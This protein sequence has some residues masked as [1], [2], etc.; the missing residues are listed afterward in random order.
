M[1]CLYD[2][3]DVLIQIRSSSHNNIV[4]I[5][6]SS[7]LVL[8]PHKSPPSHGRELPYESIAYISHGS[9]HGGP[10]SY[11]AIIARFKL[12]YS[13]LIR[14]HISTSVQE[15]QVLGF[16]DG[17]ALIWGGVLLSLHARPLLDLE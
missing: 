17:A 1:V 10:L 9:F 5:N 2:R 16:L 3:C 15:H 6:L 11:L 7:H 13:Y 12:M 4:E 8:S 14:D